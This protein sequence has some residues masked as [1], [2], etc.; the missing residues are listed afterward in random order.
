MEDGTN[1]EIPTGT[2]GRVKLVFKT[3][4]GLDWLKTYIEDAK[5]KLKFLRR[6]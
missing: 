1:D 5:M 2:R 3:G 4:N 6:T